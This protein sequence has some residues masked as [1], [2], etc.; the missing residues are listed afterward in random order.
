M[1]SLKLKNSL[2]LHTY[3]T[4]FAI[5]GFAGL[6]YESIWT[7]YLKLFLGHAAYAQ[8]LVLVIF[9]G[10]M[11]LG[12][13]LASRYSRN[14]SNLLLSYALV[15]GV[16]GVFALIFHSLFIN[17]T[18]L[19]YT[20]LIPNL[21]SV[22]QVTFLK[23]T[24]ATLLILPQSILLGSTFPLM[25]AGIIRRFPAT[26]GHSLAV[27][28]FSN[29]LGAA[30][31]I[32]VSGFVLI[33]MVGLPGTIL[34]AGLI[35]LVLALIV[36]L[37]CHD[38]SP[39]T[40]AKIVTV[41]TASSPSSPLLIA[42]LF[43]AAF[44]GLSSFLY[45]IG[46][47]RML[48]L[49][50]GSS[51]HAFELMLS[52]FIL[53]LALGGYWLR[54]RIDN[55]ANPLSVL[56]WIQIAMG[57]LALSTLLSYGHT[58]NVMQYMLTAFTKTDQGY[59]LFNLSSHGIAMLLMLPATICAGMTLPLLTYQLLAR[60]YGEK[61]I[62]GIY[63][64]NTLGAIIGVVLGVQLIMPTWG[65]KNLIT[66]G[67][68]IDILLGLALLWYASSPINKFRWAMLATTTSVAV[69]ASVWWI[70]FDPIKMASGVFRYGQL[71]PNIE[72]L[73]HR[74][75]KTA[76]VDLYR[77]G[78]EV[79]I[80]TNGKPDA[81]LSMVAEKVTI[82]EPT[83]IL[84]A[85]LPVA[86]DANLK[87]AAV[88]GLGSGLT[89]HTLL[90]M[91]TLDRVDTIEIEPAIIEAAKG[92]GTR[93]AHTFENARSH[94]YVEDA[95]TFFT[96]QQKNYDLI[97]SEPSNPWVSGVAGLFSKEFY[98]R[99]RTHLNPDGLL[100]QWFHLY[101][102]DMPLI[103]SILKAM[104]P[105]FAD[106]VIYGIAGLD[107][108]IVAKKEGQVPDPTDKIF[109]WPELT[110]TLTRIDILHKQDLWLRKIANKRMLQPLFNSYQLPANSDYFPVLDLGAVKA[111]YLQKKSAELIDLRLLPLPLVEVVTGSSLALSPPTLPVTETIYTVNLQARQAQAI[112]QYF[113]QLA[114]PKF[115]P[116]VALNH[117]NVTLIREVGSWQEHLCPLLDNK[118][119]KAQ[120]ETA[121]QTNWLPALHSLQE[122]MLPFLSPQEM[123][124]IWSAIESAPCWNDLP[125]PVKEM[126]NLYTA[127]SQR[128]FEQILSITSRLLP[129]GPIISSAEHDYLMMASLLAHIAL[130]QPTAAKL[131]WERYTTETEPSL[132]L[133]WLVAIALQS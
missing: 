1:D 53:G 109:S 77:H 48:S 21:T 3:F 112:Y 91:P 68:G 62:G 90:T 88:I 78:G 66:I 100:V 101:E 56:G 59:T 63:A 98:Q 97:I 5:S 96:N 35:N 16:I 133:R 12:A 57:L 95:K 79:T 51:T 119:V 87:T 36:W 33:E 92:F 28:Y 50:L 47:I 34:T 111:R 102:M 2:L 89:T 124:I 123:L 76:S 94:L 24:L 122:T 7:H 64:A 45:E 131:L 126:L 14:F 29:S 120:F 106:Y 114:D 17:T 105:Y 58:F 129:K 60:G 99:I 82:D 31:G 74:D 67:G 84:A 25:S 116:T 27:L 13:W 20:H 30:I 10:G 80:S 75:G 46:W 8:T 71:L 73:F 54:R 72:I 69:M 121:I 127:I 6:I 83:M 32:L 15:E 113:Q 19:A 9:M 107:I 110:S 38:D 128:Q 70:Q 11:A 39:I 85:V 55:F 49:V 115:T 40:S 130:H 43:T 86:I 65:V 117:H 104:S 52:A 4:L 108:I 37:L 103:A 22:T 132:E 61:V 44:T 125:V 93:V 23:W 118:E 42:F 26:P 41:K 18:E 81:T